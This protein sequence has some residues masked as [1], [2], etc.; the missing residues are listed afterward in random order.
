[1]ITVILVDDEKPSL[2]ELE[3]I[4]SKFDYV[5]II[6][7]Y[8]DSQ[9]ALEKIKIQEPDLVFLDIN[10]PVLS[11]MDIAD[12]INKLN[13]NTSVIFSTAYDQHALSAF[14]KNAVDYILKPY[15]C[16]RIL[17]AIRKFKKGMSDENKKIPISEKSS[18]V[19]RKMPIWK[20]DK[21]VF[22]NI[23]DILFCKVDE[24]EVFINTYT[25]TYTVN[26]SLCSLEGK[27]PKEFFL[28]THRSYIVNISKIE[29]VTPYFNHTLMIKVTGAK[30]LI[31][32]SRSN[33]KAFKDFLKIC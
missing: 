4:L 5:E 28:K 25:D 8:L 17:Q 13:L 12:K 16:D 20:G 23:E 29:E 19:I 26:E 32:V 30:E 1:M 6:G 9:E 22:V 11:G 21:I 7:K 10:M 33:V 31:P 18:N 2:D 24:G 15:D 3:Y 14:E 27:L